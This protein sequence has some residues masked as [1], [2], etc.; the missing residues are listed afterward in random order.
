MRLL[1][2][3]MDVLPYDVV[4]LIKDFCG[5]IETNNGKFKE[6]LFELIGAKKWSQKKNGLIELL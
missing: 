4:N 3:N 1:Y 5:D 6:V 2:T